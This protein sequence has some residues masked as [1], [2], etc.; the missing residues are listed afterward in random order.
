MLFTF[1]NVRRRPNILKKHITRSADRYHRPNNTV[2]YSHAFRF[3]QSLRTQKT[4]ALNPRAWVLYGV[5]TMICPPEAVSPQTLRQIAPRFDSPIADRITPR[6]PTLHTRASGYDGPPLQNNTR[7]L[8]RGMLTERNADTQHTRVEQHDLPPEPHPFSWPTPKTVP[9]CIK[10][11]SSKRL[12]MALRNFA[13]LV[14][15]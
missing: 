1:S 11:L 5:H 4:L 14:G 2:V 9:A 10:Q 3:A 6:G 13:C 7:I 15:A 8:M 12:S